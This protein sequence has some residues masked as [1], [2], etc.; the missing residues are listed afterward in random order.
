[1]MENQ[2]LYDYNRYADMNRTEYRDDKNTFYQSVY[3]LDAFD[4]TKKKLKNGYVPVLVK[5]KLSIT[6]R[7][8]QLIDSA[9]QAL[10]ELNHWQLENADQISAK[11]DNATQESDEMTPQYHTFLTVSFCVFSLVLGRIS[12]Y[13]I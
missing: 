1:M 6:L 4:P 7:K 13:I 5:E 11:F 3:L 10:E 9:R 12:H 8:Y 2:D